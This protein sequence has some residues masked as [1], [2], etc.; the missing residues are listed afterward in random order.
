MM[1]AL[2]WWDCIVHRAI[3]W[4]DLHPVGQASIVADTILVVGLGICFAVVLLV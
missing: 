4:G 3:A 1:A 2:F